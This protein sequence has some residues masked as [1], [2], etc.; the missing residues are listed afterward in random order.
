MSDGAA[1]RP[2]RPLLLRPRRGRS[3]LGSSSLEFVSIPIGVAAP[4]ALR[5]GEERVWSSILLS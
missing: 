3:E 1:P 5:Y 2:P 4:R